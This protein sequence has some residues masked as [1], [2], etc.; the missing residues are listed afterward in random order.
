MSELKSLILNRVKCC[1]QSGAIG[2]SQLWQSA[3]NYIEELEKL[4]LSLAIEECCDH[5][6][7]DMGAY[8]QCTYPECQKITN[9]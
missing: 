1:D 7:E 5:D 8:K 6:W 9:K 2:E 4:N 3:L